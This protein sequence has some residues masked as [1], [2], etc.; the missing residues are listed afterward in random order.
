MEIC[1][2]T[3]MV[4]GI[5]ATLGPFCSKDFSSG[6]SFFLYR[7]NTHLFWILEAIE[8]M[9]VVQKVLV[10]LEVIL[11]LVVEA[12]EIRFLSFLN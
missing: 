6:V 12:L 8:E 3:G 5:T 11:E 4:A 9:V 10:F 2:L 1:S 7:M